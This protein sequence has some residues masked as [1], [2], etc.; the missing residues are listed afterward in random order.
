LLNDESKD[1]AIGDAGKLPCDDSHNTG[2]HDNQR[3]MA[4]APSKREWSWT[5][6][7]D[8][9][10]V[11]RYLGEY[12]LLYHYLLDPSHVPTGERRGAQYWKWIPRKLNDRLTLHEERDMVGWGLVFEMEWDHATFF[13]SCTLPILIIALAIAIPLSIHFRWPASTGFALFGG[14]L[15]LDVFWFNITQAR[16]KQ[17]GLIK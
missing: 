6:H 7:E 17:K 9:P 4:A 2:Y 16:G 1:V 10:N 11:R 15:A 3:A 13:L 5:C 14:I 12:R 8:E